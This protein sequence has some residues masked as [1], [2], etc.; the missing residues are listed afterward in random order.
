[1]IVSGLTLSAGSSVAP[2]DGV[3]RTLPFDPELLLQM[4]VLL[5]M[6]VLLQMIVLPRTAELLQMI[7]SGPELLGCSR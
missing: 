6:M 1:M 3:W 5:Q 2:N 4:I 7:V